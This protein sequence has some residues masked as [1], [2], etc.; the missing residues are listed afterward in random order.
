[1]APGPPEQANLIGVQ[2]PF[3]A[4]LWKSLVLAVL[5][6]TSTGPLIIKL[7][8]NTLSDL[9][10]FFVGCFWI[11]GDI[12]PCSALLVLAIDII[13]DRKSSSGNSGEFLTFGRQRLSL[14]DLIVVI[15]I[16]LYVFDLTI[17]VSC[18]LA[19]RSSNWHLNSQHY[20]Y[21]L[22][23]AQVIMAVL[24]LLRPWNWMRLDLRNVLAKLEKFYL[25]SYKIIHGIARRLDSSPPIES[26]NEIVSSTRSRPTTKSA[27]PGS[28]VSG[29]EGRQSRT[30]KR[31]KPTNTATKSTTSTSSRLV[32][33][34]MTTSKKIRVAAPSNSATRARTRLQ[35]SRRSTRPATRSS[36]VRG[37]GRGS[38]R[39]RPVRRT[40][41]TDGSNKSAIVA[42]KVTLYRDR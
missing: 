9:S 20:R 34:R 5:L 10:A 11:L 26:P 22:F 3:V 36:T 1:M 21:A 16:L 14:H 24:Y 6:S 2:Q 7:F 13:F 39:A 37:I 33:R 29:R 38:L 28:Q 4:P 35:V 42:C 19:G 41:S 12:I 23:H 18:Q 17:W 31:K 8:G 40:A 25:F 15:N 30:V 27:D 32:S